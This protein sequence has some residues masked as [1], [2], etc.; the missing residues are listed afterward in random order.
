MPVSSVPL[1]ETHRRSAAVD[2]D[3]FKF[4]YNPL[5]TQRCVGDQGETFAGE[6]IDHR[7]DPEP[8]AVDEGI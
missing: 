6:V 8:A 2:D 5:T 3:G 7:Q 4:A 1:S